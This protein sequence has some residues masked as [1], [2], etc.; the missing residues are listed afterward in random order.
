MMVPAEIFDRAGELHHGKPKARF[1]VARVLI[2]LA[3]QI[4]LS[5]FPVTVRKGVACVISRLAGQ[6]WLG[7]NCRGREDEGQA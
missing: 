7:G 1:V 4:C 2:Q 6:H 3:G 5:R